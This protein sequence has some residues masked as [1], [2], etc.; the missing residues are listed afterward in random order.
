MAERRA[1]DRDEQAGPAAPGEH[2]PR[3]RLRL[4]L[5][6]LRRLLPGRRAP[7]ADGE[8]GRA[9]EETRR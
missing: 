2:R 9:A 6:V 3:G 5:A 7:R 8:G 4:F 1:A